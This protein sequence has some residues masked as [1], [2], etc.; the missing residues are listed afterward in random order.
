[1]KELTCIVCPNGCKLSVTQTQSGI[2]VSGAQCKRG[3]AFAM[4]EMKNPMRSL[5]TTVATAFK[6]TPRLSVKTM[7]EIEKDRMFEAMRIINS[8]L[9]VRHV[10]V[11][12]T[13]L[14]DVCGVRLV[15]TSDL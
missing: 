2:A 10:R 4:A 13:I 1:M 3:V 11:G 8:V 14:P 15:A 6:D 7:G 5:T 9:V 12:E